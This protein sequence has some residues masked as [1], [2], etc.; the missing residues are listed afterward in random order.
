M[1]RFS[2]AALAFACAVSPT[3]AMGHIDLPASYPPSSSYANAAILGSVGAILFMVVAVFAKHA[4]ATAAMACLSMMLLSGVALAAEV[5]ATVPTTAVI[6]PYGEWLLAAANLFT[7]V[8]VPVLGGFLIQAVTKVYPWAALFL[9]QKRVEQMA[10]A[11]TE[12]AVNAVPG[13]VKEGKLSIPVGSAVIAKAIQY[14]VD[15]AP[16]KALA[17][18]GGPEGLAKII[19][20]K[21]N[22]VDEANETNVLL[23]AIAKLPGK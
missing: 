19:F 14:A 15:A 3:F 4:R 22:L 8:I 13:A 23:P 16:A 2:L 11:V 10:N 18:A 17:A 6:L 12:Y 5:V 9:T 20:R 1:T 7:A 21:L